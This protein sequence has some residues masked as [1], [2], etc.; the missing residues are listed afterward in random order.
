[1]RLG[2]NYLGDGQCEFTVWAPPLK[3]VELK[4]ERGLQP[5]QQDERGYWQI[6]LNDIQPGDRYEYRLD[7]EAARPDPASHYQPGGVHEASAVVD[8]SAFDWQ[9]DDWQGIPLQDYVIYELHVGTFTPAGTFESA[10]ERLDYL[11][12]LGITAVEI[13]PVSQFAGDRNW[14][15]D[16]VYPFAVQHSYGGPD[17]L[18]KLVDACHQ[19]GLAVILDVVYNHFGPEGNYTSFFGPYLTDNYRTPWG[20]AINFDDAYSGGVRH[21]FISNALYWLELYHIDALRLD[22]IHAIYDFGAKHF[23]AELAEATAALEKSLK[24]PLYLIAESDLNDV[25]IIREAERGGYD[26]HSQWSDDFHHALHALLTKEETG[27]YSDFKAAESLA[28]AYRD[29]FVYSWK[30]SPF[31]QRYHGSDASD[32]PAH[33]FVVCSQ[34]HDQVGNRML[35]ERLSH[36]VPFEALKLAAGTVILSPYLPMLFMGEEYGET[37]PFLYFV[38]HGDPNLIAA[39]REG[40]KKEFEAFHA[41]GDPPDA[42]SLETFNQAK[43]N[44]DLLEQD[45]HRSLFGFYQ[46]LIALRQQAGIARDFARPDLD[47]VQ[48]QAVLQVHRWNSSQ[49]LLSVMNFSDQQATVKLAFSQYAWKQQLDS[50]AAEWAGEL[51]DEFFICDRALITETKP[52][53]IGQLGSIHHHTVAV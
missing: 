50:A 30:Y 53:T 24:R 49:R 25:R 35:G 13:M 21:Y 15:Y 44:W 17:G 23:L 19:R 20:S 8:H 39:V 10:I 22:A 34:N 26:I 38:D 29:S 46:R 11:K 5:M 18:K 41:E 16:G 2:A 47:V 43:L 14:G 33:Q 1:M 3:S 6:A 40:R 37:A 36:L 4:L 9:D 42:A 48:D 28:S 45:R 7:G 27:Y 31:R 32:R 12:S 51:T 52:A